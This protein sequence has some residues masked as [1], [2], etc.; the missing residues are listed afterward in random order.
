MKRALPGSYKEF[1]EAS[2]GLTGCLSKDGST[3]QKGVEVGDPIRIRYAQSK[4]SQE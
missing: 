3:K 4:F 2:N 1:L